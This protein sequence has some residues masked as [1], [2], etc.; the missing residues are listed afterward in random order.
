MKLEITDTIHKESLN[1]LD[2]KNFHIATTALQFR[3]LSIGNKEK[4]F[5]PGIWN[6]V[7][8]FSDYEIPCLSLSL[9]VSLFAE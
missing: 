9:D 3:P 5:R 6:E 4:G 1:Q 7:L 8:I 2:Y